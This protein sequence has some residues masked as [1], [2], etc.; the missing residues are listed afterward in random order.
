VAKLSA[1]ENYLRL[2]RGEMPDYVPNWTMGMNAPGSPAAMVMPSIMGPPMMGPPPGDDGNPRK[3]WTDQWGITYTA[4]EEV[5]NAGLPKPG[6]F[7]LKDVTKWDQTVKWPAYPDDFY[8]ADWEAMAKKDLEAINR[9]EIGVVAMCGFGPFTTLVNFMGFTEGLCALLEEPESVKEMLNYICDYYMPIVDKTM[10]YYS[11]DFV[12][13]LDD[14]ASKYAPFFSVPVYK[15][16]FKPIYARLGKT[17]KDRGIP[18]QFH[19]CGR[20]EDFVP[21]MIDFGVK[22]WDPAQQSNDLLKVKEQ[23]KGQISIC[24]GFDFVPAVDRETTEDDVRSYVR[25]VLDKFAPGGGYA[26]CGGITGHAKDMEKT[27]KLNEWVQDEVARYG[28]D[29]YGK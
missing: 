13:L 5:G 2:S 4:V 6:N 24:G 16:I 28:A 21:D 14:T 18:I 17:A 12:Y 25:S 3:E 1:K 29:F 11:P 23:F 15:D 19:N 9:D 27:M 22:Y 7:I 10:D 26:F 8:T 20:C